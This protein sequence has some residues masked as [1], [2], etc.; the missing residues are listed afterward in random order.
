MLQKKKKLMI[1][2]KTVLMIV[3]FLRGEGERERREEVLCLFTLVAS[4]SDCGRKKKRLLLLQS[5]YFRADCVTYL[6]S[7]GFWLT[8]RNK[9]AKQQRANM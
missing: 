4:G 8:V 9:G 3:F 5:L 7:L 2:V 1:D 6:V